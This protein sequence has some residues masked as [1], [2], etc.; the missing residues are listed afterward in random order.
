MYGKFFDELKL[1]LDH[2]SQ[3]D[4]VQY[5]SD[6]GLA[7]TFLVNRAEQLGFTLPSQFTAASFAQFL[8]AQ[9]LDVTPGLSTESLRS[10]QNKLWRRILVS[11]PE[12]IRSKGTRAAVSGILNTLGFGAP[13]SVSDN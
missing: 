3:F 11:L 12:I 10:A 8:L 9:N 13:E 6:E 7:E 1:Y 2:F 4:N 5:E